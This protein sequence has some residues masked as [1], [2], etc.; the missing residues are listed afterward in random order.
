MLWIGTAQGGLN[1]FNKNQKPFRNYSHNPYDKQSLS[2]NLIT[3]IVEDNEGKIWLSFFESS[4]CRTE[5]KLNIQSRKQIHFEQLKKQ[6]T[7]LTDQWV[8]HLYQD[9]K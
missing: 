6:L 7:S 9:F 5:E 4:I 1:R 2:S 8:L 3:D